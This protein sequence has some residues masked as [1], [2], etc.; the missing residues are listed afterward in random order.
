MKHVFLMG[1][2]HSLHHGHT[3]G[4]VF[5][6]EYKA[7][8][9][10][11]QRCSNPKVASFKDYGGRGI[12]VCDRWLRSF[13][14]FFADVGPRPSAKHSLD[15]FPDN[16]GN[17]EPGN[18]RWATPEEQQNNRRK[19]VFLEA[20]GKTQSFAEWVR[21][22]GLPADTLWR[23]INV[24]KWSPERALTTSL[25][26]KKDRLRDLVI[27][28]G[29]ASVSDFLMRTGLSP[30]VVYAYANGKSQRA[31]TVRKLETLLGLI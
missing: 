26:P 10:M 5:T 27:R 30:A 7:W 24:W 17:Y 6:P 2:T 11:K 3:R 25:P 1:N 4:G 8:D 9:S 29:Y 19:T 16:D 14:A 23:R 28:A 13:E 31:E 18:V 15:R 22:T 21:E 20:M 12:R